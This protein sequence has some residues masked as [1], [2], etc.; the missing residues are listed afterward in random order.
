M[1]WKFNPNGT[2]YL[3]ET[4]LTNNPV[5]LHTSRN[6]VPI[7]QIAPN[8]DSKEFKSLGIYKPAT[9]TDHYELKNIF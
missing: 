4:V 8:Y 6:S 9:L 2:P 3:D 5:L 7:Q 1:N